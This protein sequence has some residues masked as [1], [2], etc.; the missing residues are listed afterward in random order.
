MLDI[1]QNAGQIK[2]AKGLVALVSDWMDRFEV[3][4]D[5]ELQDRLIN[6]EASEFLAVFDE[7]EEPTPEAV[8]KLLKE[9]ADVMFTSI[10]F[11]V[12]ADR[13]GVHGE[14]FYTEDTTEK[15]EAAL[16]IF[17]FFIKLNPK[18]ADRIFTEAFFRVVQSNN[19]KLDDN[20]KPVRDENGKVLK[21]PNYVE[22]DLSDLGQKLY[23][24]TF[25]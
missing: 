11:S 25:A 20:G 23:D 4:N 22:P 15:A 17:G 1:P 3:T 14:V 8:S 12:M 2:G 10:G 21:G 16:D 24:L 19:S 5:L 13:L 9:I 7:N 18:E 6:E